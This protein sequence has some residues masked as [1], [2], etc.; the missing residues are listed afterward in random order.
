MFS[1]ENLGVYQK[2]R[3]LV[4]EVYNLQNKFPAEERYALGDQIRRSI[5]SVTSNIAE[6]SGRDTNKDK[7]HFCVIAFGSLMEAFSQ[8]HNAQD[9]GYISINEVESLRPQ[10]EE[11]SKMPSGL[12]SSSEK[13][14]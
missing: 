7:A 4:K 3:V 11:I 13:Q 2:A 12:Q 8:L 5:T 10:L 1:F 9:L 14:L 6:G